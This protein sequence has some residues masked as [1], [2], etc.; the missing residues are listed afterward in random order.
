MEP[1]IRTGRR[2]ASLTGEAAVGIAPLLLAQVAQPPKGALDCSRADDRV[3]LAFAQ[4]EN[5]SQGGRAC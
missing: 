2:A 1:R 5:R 3:R 4:A